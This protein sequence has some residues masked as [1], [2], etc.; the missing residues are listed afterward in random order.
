[1]TEVTP[2]TQMM[3]MMRAMNETMAKQQEL[4]MKLLEDCD[5]NQ[6][7]HET[8]EEN[9]VIAGSGGTGGE[10]LT[11]GVA[12]LETRDCEERQKVKY[13][14]QLLWGTTLTWWNVFTSTIEESVLAKMSWAEFKKKILEEYCTE[15]KL[16]AIEEE[17]W[18]IKKGDLSV[19]E[20]T[21]LFMEK[22]DL[23]GHVAPTEKEKVK[24]Y[25]KGLPAD[26]IQMVRNSKASNLRE[27]IEEAKVTERLFAK[28]KTEK[29]KTVEKR[30]Q[31]KREAIPK[32]QGRAFQMTKE[33]AKETAEVVS[34][35]FL[36]NSTPARVLFD[37]GANFSFVSDVFCKSL[38]LLASVLS[39]AL[40]I[41][42]ANGERVVLRDILR[43]CRLEINGETFMVDLLPM[44]IGSFDVVIG[45]DW[46]AKYQAEILCSRKLIRIP[47]RD[48]EFL[49]VYGEKRKGEVAII[50]SIKA[51]KYLTKNYPSYVAFVV[52]AKAE[53]RRIAPYHLA[54]T[55]MQ[56]M[57][58]QLQE[59]LEKGFVRPSSSPW[60]APV[61]FVKKKDGSMRMCIDYRELNKVTI[62]NKYPLPRI[63]DLFDQLQGAGC[64]SKI[65][66]RSRYHQGKVREEDVPKTSFRTR[67]GHYEF[68]L[69]E[70]KFLGH[71]VTREGVKVDPAKIK[72]MM[73]W[74]P[75]KS[76]TEIR[77]FLGL[78]GY[79]RRFIQ[80]FSKIASSLTALTR[81]NVKLA[82]TEAQEKAFRT[83]QRKLCETPILSL[84]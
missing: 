65:D 14:S 66:L 51:R 46:L 39:D 47:I 79:Y 7:R 15:E 68:L 76:P 75:P 50:S 49:F 32:A 28:D 62:K 44:T 9:I 31:T 8:I 41:E 36:L 42:I 70:V 12:T 24:S 16:Y 30:S 45:M 74:E 18:S 37:S 22:L 71:V 19:K 57:M 83:L 84:P 60:G 25:L 77:S 43:E 5:G 33:E 1:M 78:A 27:T 17:F 29:V 58:S 73:N 10:I 61:L 80:D 81:K 13:G 38:N 82:W 72:A 34:G 56:E 11:D 40:I 64:F 48:G 59:F 20:Y 3:D 23:V 26:M 4:F 54:P 6:R 53:K 69:R 63:D 2:K 52:D 21:R 67:Y 35:T 55:E